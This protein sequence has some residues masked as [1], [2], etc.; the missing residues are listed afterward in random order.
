[1][2]TQLRRLSML[3]MAVRSIVPAGVAV[4]V[5]SP[6][7][8]SDPL[9]PIEEQAIAEAQPARKKEFAAGRTA[10]RKALLALGRAP[11]AIPMGGDRAPVWPR[12]VVGSITH[13]SKACIA[14]VGERDRFKALGIDIEPA[15]PLEA[16]LF[17][18]ICRPEE[19]A[20]LRQLPF[21]TRGVVAR[22]FFSVKEAI[23]KC[24]YAVS[25][26]LFDFHT[27]SVIFDKQ[28]RFDA[29]LMKDV[30]GFAKGTMFRGL[31]TKS[32]EQ[33]IS[34]CYLSEGVDFGSEFPNSVI[35]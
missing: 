26:E 33:I 3:E 28:G 17:S 12:A 5:T 11:S 6:R 7:A 19:L 13:D 25:G 18:E 20:W 8:D 21:E 1:M 15:L 2:T 22:R 9:W 4:A 27:L 35:G 34:L 10:S 16:D 31:T 30:E 24:Q 23:Y 32:G 29:R 14:V